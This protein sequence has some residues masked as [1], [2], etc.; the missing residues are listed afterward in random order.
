MKV[1]ELNGILMFGEFKRVEQVMH[2]ANH[3]TK[4]NQPVPGMQKVVIGVGPDYRFEQMASFNRQ[5]LATF[6]E[7]LVSKIV[8][9][10]SGLVGKKVAV[11]IAVRANKQGY[12][13]MEALNVY[14]L[15]EVVA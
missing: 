8:G 7:S 14:V 6:E 13:N 15:D 12:V 2:G 11:R 3:A 1:D 10:G 5:D 9:D 4:P